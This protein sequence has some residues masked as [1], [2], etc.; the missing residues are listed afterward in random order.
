MAVPVL[1][2]RLVLQR[3]ARFDG[4]DGSQAARYALPAAPAAV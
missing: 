1:A 3:E 4:Y 2:H